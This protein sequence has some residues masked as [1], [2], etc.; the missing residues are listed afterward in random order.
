MSTLTRNFGLEKP[1]QTDY[2]NV[3]VF[4][5]NADI[6]D[7]ELSKSVKGEGLEF[8]VVNN[9]L[10]VTHES[11][12][13]AQVADK[14]TVDEV[15]ALLE[16][17][18]YGLN[19]LKSLVSSGGVDLTPVTNQLNNTTYGLSAIK[20]AINGRANESTLTA[21]KALLENTTYGLNA[22]KTAIANNVSGVNTALTDIATLWN[23]L[24]NSTYGLSVIKNYVDTL[25]SVIGTT[26]NTGGT[27]SAGTVMAKLNALLT[28]IS[29]GTAKVTCIKKIF[30]GSVSLPNSYD[31]YTTVTLPQ[32]CDPDKCFVMLHGLAYAVEDY[33][34]WA[35]PVYYTLTDKTIK[36][37]TGSD[38]FSGST[39]TVD[40][41]IIEFY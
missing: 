32:T 21:T 27:A 25:E 35:I 11:G 9:T 2:Y 17:T 34:A 15:L 23:T 22:L 14:A 24:N 12:A 3:D 39:F 6:I 30:R 41:Q 19:A 31:F 37:S 28:G 38:V 26:A 40:Y 4:N 7:E 1:D 20:T 18:T 16:N 29:G 33:R 13:T 5:A 8:S 10:N 36:I